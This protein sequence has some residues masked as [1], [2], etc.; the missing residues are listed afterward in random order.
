ML[1]YVE[2]D[3]PLGINVNL[4]GVRPL[5]AYRSVACEGVSALM[6][7]FIFSALPLGPCPRLSPKLTAGVSWSPLAFLIA[8]YHI[9]LPHQSY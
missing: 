6:L 4:G 2:T 9:Q 5:Q 1:T 3:F 7:L 8:F